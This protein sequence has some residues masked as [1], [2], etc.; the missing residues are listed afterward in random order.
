MNLFRRLFIIVADDNK[1]LATTLSLLLKLVG[2]EIATVHD[3]RDA[4][5]VATNRPPISS[6][7]IS[8]FRG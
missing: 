2:F 1:D 5:A 8:A 4:V 3:G 6:S 7:S